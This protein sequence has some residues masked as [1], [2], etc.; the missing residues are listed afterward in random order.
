[1]QQVATRPMK[2]DVCDD[3]G[4][5]VFVQ[6]LG[7]IY[8]IYPNACRCQNNQF[9]DLVRS[10]WQSS[11]RWCHSMPQWWV[12]W[13]MANCMRRQLF[14]MFRVP[15][16]TDTPSHPNRYERQRR[17]NPDRLSSMQPHR[18]SIS[19]ICTCDAKHWR[20]KKKQWKNCWI[21]SIGKALSSP[22]SLYLSLLTFAFDMKWIRWKIKWKNNN[23]RIEWVRRQTIQ[24]QLD[25][26]QQNATHTT[27]FTRSENSPKKHFLQKLLLTINVN[28]KVYTQKAI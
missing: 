2:C 17:D 15:N 23:N 16:R 4:W 1:M 11:L 22:H 3:G 6:L 18:S 14:Q 25:L 8:S 21:I 12:H 13:T 10:N 28:S 24:L 19:R 7:F 5:N 9:Y 26:S 27:T 20:K